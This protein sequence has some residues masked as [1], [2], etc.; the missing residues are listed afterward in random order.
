VSS[1]AASV[2]QVNAERA[3]AAYNAMQQAMYV[4]NGTGLYRESAPWSG[5]PYSY[6]WPFSRALLGTLALAGVPDNLLA[7]QSFGQA[8]QDRLDGLAKYWDGSGRRPA[9]ASYVTPPLG[10]GGDKYYDDNAWIALAL[11]QQYRMGLSTSLTRVEQLFTFAQH[12]WKSDPT[13]PMPGGVFWVEQGIGHGLTNHDRGAGATAG[14]AEVGLHIAELTGSNSVVPEAE[15]MVNWVN[16]HLDSSRTGHGPFLNVVRRDGSIDTNVWSYNQGV[17]IGA[18]VLRYR[19]RRDAIDLR[20][21]EGIARQTLHTFGDFAGHPPSFNAMCF[22]N[23]LILHA[24]TA[25]RELQADMLHAMRRF[26]DWAWDPRTGA[27]DPTTN[28]FYFTDAGQPARGA[29]PAKLQ[30]QGAMVQLHALL[31]WNADDYAALT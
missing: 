24:A 8:A 6:V 23:M 10:G 9:Y 16:Q 5:N 20:R 12:G 4:S 22:Q 28:L 29:Q 3:V 13:A 11:I 31:A 18:N 2:Q 25:D 1:L 30:D 14:S 21:A 7:N 17:M 26:A 15:E 27:R 19:R